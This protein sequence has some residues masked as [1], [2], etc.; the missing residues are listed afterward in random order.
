MAILGCGAIALAI[1]G[2]G[3]GSEAKAGGEPSPSST[4]TG[5]VTWRASAR[6]G[7]SAQVVIALQA[8]GQ[9]LEEV[10]PAPGASEKD[11]EKDRGKAERPKPKP[12]RLKVQTRTE[13]ADRVVAID[14]R[15]RAS[16][17]ARRVVQASSAINGEVRTRATAIRPEVALLL[18][19]R[20][21]D[22][23]VVYSPSGPLTRSELEVVEGVGDPLALA[24]LLPDRPVAV[25]ETWRVGRD[26]ARGLS[27]YDALAAHTL[28]ATLESLDAGADAPTALI[29]LK[30]E[31]RGA[32]LGGEGTIR[33][34][35]TLHVDR[36]SG[37]IRRLVL[38]RHET[39]KAGPVEEGLDIRST[40]TVECRPIATPDALGD[41]IIAALP[42]DR[43]SRRELLLLISPDGK[44]SL[45]HDRDWHIYWD[46]SRL[47]VLKRLDHGEV[48]AQCNL[49]AGPKV[50][51]G[52]HQD[53]D[54][55]RDD[56]R[57]A[58]G[59][60][61][62]RFAG[63]GEVDGEPAG[64]FRY[65]VAVEG[66]QGDVPLL[67]DYYLLAG[68]DGDQVLATFTRAAHSAPAFGDQDLRLI[69]SFRWTGRPEAKP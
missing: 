50:P 58:L 11:Q 41:P 46:D 57:R 49:N 38:D 28:D 21:D 36:D 15:G 16:R 51:A 60:R 19:E 13:F 26:A 23:I 56:V 63:V 37:Q 68:P 43:D 31:I 22:A 65:K 32:V 27:G 69:A 35:G 42:R 7:E 29:R 52:K 61:F 54:Q 25:G 59:A 3:A 8:E 62:V 55:F 1:L 12:R 24:G 39:R 20:R 17:S 5:P 64:G 47:T 66:R 4:P 34:D 30:G 10:A 45:E 40:L 44:Y 53:P 18:A 9:F 2:I 33:C 67:W 6:V 14:A 48:I